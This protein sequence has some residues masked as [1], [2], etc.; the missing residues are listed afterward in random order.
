MEKI[1]FT[2]KMRQRDCC[3][4]VAKLKSLLIRFGYSRIAVGINSYGP[5]TRT[6]VLY[7]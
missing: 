2:Q 5:K 1:Y 6:L 3:A 4:D 7:Y